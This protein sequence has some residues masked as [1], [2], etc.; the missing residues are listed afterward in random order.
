M[1]LST[2]LHTHTC[3]FNN[4]FTTKLVRIKIPLPPV[5]EKKKVV[6]D[7]DK[8]RKHAIDAAIVRVMKSRKVGA[9]H[10]LLLARDMKCAHCLELKGGL[11]VVS[12]ALRAL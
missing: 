11:C 8:D 10:A 5:D 9:V 7:V 12:K 4:S 3:S 2:S 1:L 6:E